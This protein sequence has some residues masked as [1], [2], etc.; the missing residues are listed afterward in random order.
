MTISWNDKLEVHKPTT[1]END[2]LRETLR[3]GPSQLGE[4]EED[5]TSDIDEKVNVKGLATGFQNCW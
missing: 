3:N 4:N 2:S 1:T 5:I